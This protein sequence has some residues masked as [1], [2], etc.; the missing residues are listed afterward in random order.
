MRAINR[1]WSHRETQAVMPKESHPLF[2]LPHRPTPIHT[3]S[4]FHFQSQLA[5]LQWLFILFSIAPPGIIDYL[6]PSPFIVPFIRFI[7]TSDSSSA[8]TP[9]NTSDDKQKI[10]FFP[11]KTILK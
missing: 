6:R 3:S 10:L 1:G 7:T 8:L 4:L 11:P 9:P 5:K 2:A